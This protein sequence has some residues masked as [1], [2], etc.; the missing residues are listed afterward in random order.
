M[1]FVSVPAPEAVL[2]LIRPFARLSFLAW[3][4]LCPAGANGLAA[5]AEAPKASF[6]VPAG[7]A[8]STLRQFSQQASAPII[9]PI[10]TVRGVT[11]NPVQ[12]EF[13]ARTALDRMV[14]GTGLI[15][16]Q[17]AS[18]GALT[19]GRG[20]PPPAPRRSPPT[21]PLNEPASTPMKTRPV[22]AAILG[23]LAGP[24][25]EAQTAPP[26]PGAPPAA[27]APIVM[28]EFSVAGTNDGWVATNAL[29][30]TR[31][32]M[33]LRELP[34]SIQ[35]VTS[36]F[37]NDIGALTLT[38]AT[39]YMSGITNVGNQDQTNDNNTYQV[40]GF[41]QNKP[42]RNGMREP[43][44]GMLFDSA[45]MDRAEVLKGP[46]SLLAG[47][48]EPGGM[49]NAISKVPRPKR[50]TTLALRA[51]TGACGVGRSTRRFR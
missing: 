18:T 28:S 51:T 25:A 29:S 48:A 27:D 21:P 11:T 38:D 44:A 12:G 37:M 4:W 1:T 30:G 42:Y 7:D 40:R 15:V 33:N 45:T 41:R 43:F 9:Y 35:V 13:T 2:R 46:S 50:E 14:A 32:N 19:V 23:F 31:T 22:L 3:G 8:A 6:R 36:E 24:A 5:P 47:V 17:D 34:R 26:A 20:A 49:L 10:D 39:D 16:A